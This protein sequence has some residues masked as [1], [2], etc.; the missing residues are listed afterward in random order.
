MP[1]AADYAYNYKKYFSV[2][3]RKMLYFSHTGMGS[4]LA[5]RNRWTS[6]T[7]FCL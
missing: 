2:T 7:V 1:K 4:E 6:N 5:Y 3:V